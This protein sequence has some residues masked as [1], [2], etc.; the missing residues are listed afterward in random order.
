ARRGI[1]E[2]EAA[3]GSVRAAASPGEGSNVAFEREIR[4]L[5]A[6]TEDQA[7]EIARLKAA[8][9]AFEQQDGKAGGLKD[10]RIALRARLGSAQAAGRRGG[11]RRARRRRPSRKLDASRPPLPTPTGTM[12]MA[13]PGPRPRKKRR[14]KVAPLFPPPQKCPKPARY[15]ASA[16]GLACSIAS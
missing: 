6:R 10:S 14:R 1:S 13:R 12:P 16:V 8:L 15:Q 11:P 9:V 4:A 5:K 3:I 2:A 7:G